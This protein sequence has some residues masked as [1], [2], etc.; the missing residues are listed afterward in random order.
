LAVA[1]AAV[2]A[3]FETDILFINAPLDGAVDY[4][5]IRKI[6]AAKRR[7]NVFL[8]LVTEGG[9]ADCAFR[10]ARCLQ[11]LY[12]TFTVVVPGWCKSAGTLLCVGA[13][14]LI[15]G[16][17]GELGPLDV[18]VAKLDELAQFSSGLTIDSAFRGLQSVAFQ[19]FETF[20]LDTVA[21]SHGR[22]TTKTAA[23]LSANITVGLLAPV[24][25]QMDPMKIGDDFRSTRIAEGYALRLDGH[26]RNL[27]HDDE[28]DAIEALVRGYPSHGFVIDRTEAQ[29]LFHRVSPLEGA[30]VEVIKGL[31]DSI[32]PLS[33]PRQQPIVQYLTKEVT[34]EARTG[35]DAAA[36]GGKPSARKKPGDEP[37][38]SEPIPPNTP[39]GDGN[40]A[41]PIPHEQERAGRQNKAPN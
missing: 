6:C 33:S 30:L 23:E 39:R 35:P 16:D 11:E 15:I 18:Q 40:I 36:T 31:G 19:M 28:M 5:A 17:L 7:K 10:I 25:Q 34:D 22:I 1:V 24:F 32:N 38:G 21:K 12:E 9:S 41:V 8:I 20:L 4:T 2:S 27:V 26:S 29:S 13:Y 3:E 14:D 37:Q